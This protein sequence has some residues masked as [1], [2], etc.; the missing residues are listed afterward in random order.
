MSSARSENNEHAPAWQFWI[1]R[2]GTF[3]DVIARSP[4][5]SLVIRKLLSED[6]GRYDDA[7]VAGIER[8]LEDAGVNRDGSVRVDAIKMG[9]T[10]ATNALLER[11]GEPTVLVAT[12][13]FRDALRIGY[14]NRPDI[15]ALNIKLP[16]QLYARVVEIDERLDASG[17]V[18]M[19]PAAAAIERD[20][21]REF[22]AGYRSVAICLL[23][24]YRNAEH[25]RLVADVATRI[26]FAQVSPSHEVSPLRKLVS[27]G[28]TTV[29][30]AYL[31]P[32]LKRYIERLKTGLADARLSTPHLMF[33]QS[34][35]G[36]VDE[37]FFRG[38][39]SILSGPAGGVVGMAGASGT[40]GGNRLIGF[41]MGGTSTDVSL[42]AGEFDL[43]TDTEIAGVRMRSPMIRV[44]TIAAGGGSI[45]KFA[46]GRFQV[47]PESAGADPGPV[48]YRCGG[49]LTVTD[50]NVLLRRILPDRFPH[51]FGPRGDEPLDATAVA[52]RFAAIAAEISAQIGRDM[53]PEDVADG[54]IRIAVDNMANAIKRVSIQRGF[55]PAEFTLCCF[56][57]AGGQ[58]ACRVADQLGIRRILVHPL[59][60]VLSA[61]GM[62]IAP[63]RSYRHMT[64]ERRLSK[65]ALDDLLAAATA[66]GD[67][68]RDQL[69]AQRVPRDAIRIRTILDIKVDGADTALPI[70]WDTASRVGEQFE[71]AHRR[72]FGFGVAGRDLAIESLRV[73]A[74]GR[75]RA[76]AFDAA[77][78]QP[79]AENDDV[80]ARIY[81]RGRWQHATV[82]DRNALASGTRIDGPAVV[83]ERTS[84]TVVDAGWTMLVEDDGQLS[85]TRDDN[86]GTRDDYDTDAD[87]V[88]LEVFNSHF[89]N[90]AEQMGAVLE[91]TAH[92][93]NIK[94]RLD[95][96]C[97]LFDHAGHLIANAPHMPVHLGSM[98][99]SVQAILRDNADTLRPG[100]AYLL[101]T[102]YNG[103]SHLP[104][105][106]VVT[107]VFDDAGANVQFVVACRAHHADIGGL[108][109]GSMPPLSQTIDEEGALF[110]NFKLVDQGALREAELRA[111][112]AAGR[113]PARNPDQNVADVVAQLAANAKGV[114][115][116]RAMIRHFGRETVAAYMRHVQNN[117]DECVR[118]VIDRLHDGNN[119]VEL[120]NG[121][122]IRVAINV[123][124][125]RR[126]AEVS[127]DG[128]SPQSP[129]NFNAP[130]AVTRAAVLYV[131]RTLVAENIPLNAGCLIPIRLRVPDG[132]LLNP[133][134]PAAVVAGNV[135]TSQ[136][137]TNA[138]YGA[139][140]VVAAAQ[141]T[142]NNLTFGNE[143]Y[144]Y[145]ETIC[146]G[147]GAGP[148]F[149]GT[150]AVHTAMTNSR[151]TD[152]EVLE[153]RYP[154][155]VVE[156]TVR[157][158]SGGRG[159]HRGGDGVIRKLEFLEPMQAAILSNNRTTRPPGLAGGEPGQ[160]GRNYVLHPD[161][162]RTDLGPVAEFSVSAGDVLVIETPGG[163]GYGAPVPDSGGR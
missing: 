64:V 27:R 1:D 99:D 125:E 33:M 76:P 112:L 48:A 91:N 78:A 25:E 162:T 8:I 60:G 92:S 77:T 57:G 86:D 82:H 56:G 4:D 98:G 100:D 50:A 109:P 11:R 20:L 41:D 156:F 114:R 87:P 105:I 70:K 94:E 117:A 80:D 9:T 108:T 149:D 31:S 96:S 24:A 69:I 150:D 40:A 120:D 142:M 158:G 152:P 12:R 84:T 131:F 52:E 115:E 10:V 113:W 62:G 59:A 93:V 123:D 55:D 29:A 51:V 71:T 135:E 129:T 154:I 65:S 111:G 61:F 74:S 148:D 151:L 81:D 38:K 67:A 134:Y 22:D 16:E 155:R 68:C 160:A 106:T 47:G 53:S 143:S 157:R 144:Q 34:N 107:P 121:A 126:E 5:G 119:V 58:H 127:F 63:L 75:E 147:S 140:G 46:S 97:A 14:Q 36:L 37:A 110:D 139:L 23:N 102:P 2:G 104:D 163:G 45:L 6:P 66:A 18:L 159:R 13:G 118:S 54:F 28:D 128:T 19:P 42:Y 79:G 90:V 35:G 21:R 145:Y 122:G 136:V 101:N 15:F 116:L 73:E 146:G 132:S 17:G 7:A 44:H 26:G 138:I 161:G 133:A 137:V 89:M 83:T 30:D 32:V 124:A 43:V 88:L 3:T 130:V 85:L 72:R 141:G 49:P 39:D 95:F 103:G 153:A